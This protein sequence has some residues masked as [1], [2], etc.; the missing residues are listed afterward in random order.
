MYF[1]SQQKLGSW[2]LHSFVNMPTSFTGHIEKYAHLAY[3]TYWK[4]C[5]GNFTNFFD[6]FCFLIIYNVTFRNWKL[7][8]EYRFKPSINNAST[9]GPTWA[10]WLFFFCVSINIQRFDS[11]PFF[12]KPKLTKITVSQELPRF[13]SHTYRVGNLKV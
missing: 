7:H 5:P 3:W 1:I 4:M 12:S 9:P 11:I 2:S 8:T 6:Q 10:Y 13:H